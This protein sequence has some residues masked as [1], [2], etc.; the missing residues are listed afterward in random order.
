MVGYGV[1]NAKGQVTIPADIRESLGILPGLS[2]VIKKVSDAVVVSPVPDIFSLRG[3]VLSRRKMNIKK[4]EEN[5]EKYLGM[6][7]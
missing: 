3:S 5:F 1:I 6:N 2:V 7:K 4:M